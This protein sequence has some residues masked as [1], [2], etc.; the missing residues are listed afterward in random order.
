MLGQISD[1]SD[2]DARNRKDD[3]EDLVSGDTF[4]QHHM[5]EEDHKDRE[6]AVND[7]GYIGGTSHKAQSQKDKIPSVAE[8]PIEERVLCKKISETES[9]FPREGKQNGKSDRDPDC[10]EQER[11]YAGQGDFGSD[12]SGGPDKYSG[13]YCDIVFNSFS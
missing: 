10:G 1:G 9:P 13:E 3:T 12:K 6:Q 2:D 7:R 11:P 5:T 8:N 4:V